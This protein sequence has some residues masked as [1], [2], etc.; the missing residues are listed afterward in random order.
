MTHIS[1]LFIS[2]HPTLSD[3]GNAPLGV[4]FEAFTSRRFEAFTSR[5]YDLFG[6]TLIFRWGS[7]R[8]CSFGLSFDVL[9]P[10][11]KGRR[12]LACEQVVPPNIIANSS[13][14]N[15]IHSLEFS[16]DCGWVLP[17]H[18]VTCRIVVLP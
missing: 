14:F 3:A 4:A 10:V 8:S 1:P 18:S 6:R 15:S 11:P 12:F 9:S 7:R 13:V 2:F 17:A 5:R 16:I